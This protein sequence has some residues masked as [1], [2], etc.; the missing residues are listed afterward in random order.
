[1]MFTLVCLIDVPGRLLI[2]KENSLKRRL[3]LLNKLLNKKRPGDPVLFSTRTFIRDPP[4]IR[5]TRV[6]RY[7]NINDSTHMK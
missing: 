1:M 5:H 7:G 2:F 6:R 4:Y 3:F